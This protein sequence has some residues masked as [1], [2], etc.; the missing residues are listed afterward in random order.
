MGYGEKFQREMR[1]WKKHYFRTVN[2]PK[3]I[4]DMNFD[5]HQTNQ[6]RRKL[7][8]GTWQ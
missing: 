5:K 2:F 4:K 1:N 7:K 8:I 3:Q 6:I